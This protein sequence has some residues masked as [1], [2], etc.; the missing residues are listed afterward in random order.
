M[1]R[2]TILIVEDNAET[3]GAL[4][5]LLEEEGYAV[6]QAE[7]GGEGILLAHRRRPDLIL[8]DVAMPVVDGIDAAESLKLSPSTRGIPIVAITGER[9]RRQHERIRRVCD[10]LLLKPCPPR[11]ILGEVGRLMEAP[12]V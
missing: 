1:H 2:K 4:A 5:V 12:G 9:L 7:H 10:A 6:L 11:D 3:R 8:M